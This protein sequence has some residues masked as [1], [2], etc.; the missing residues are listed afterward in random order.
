MLTYYF[1]FK[2]SYLLALSVRPPR[3][4]TMS[5]HLIPAPFTLA[6][7]NSYWASVSL[8]TLP[9]AK[10]L[11]WSFCPSGQMF[12]AGFLQIPPHDGDPCH[13]LYDSRY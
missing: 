13:W 2:A 8:A 11:I 6:A 3:I 7:P 12:A 10:S 5:F 1:A 4:R 9:A